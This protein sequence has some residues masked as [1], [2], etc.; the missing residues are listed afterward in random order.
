MDDPVVI[1]SAARTPIG[2]FVGDFA[3]LAAHELGAAAIRAAVQRAGVKPEDVEEVLFGC[4]LQAGLGQ[5][6]ARQ[7]SAASAGLPLAA[8]CTTI[9]KMCG[10]AMKA[11]M[12]AHDLILAGTDRIIVAGGM[13][14][15]DQR[16]LPDAQGARRLPDGPRQRARPHVPG[17]PGGCLRQGPADGH[18]RRGLRAAVRFHPRGAGRVRAG[19]AHARAGREH[20]RHLRLGDRPGDRRRQEGRTSSSA[21]TSSPRRPRR[22]RSRC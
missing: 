1:V 20:R 12:L 15:D 4:V 7:A 6:P 17:R 5:A 9:N 14:I 13:E 11:T 10:S 18:L 22:T 8:G 2:G 3:S 16:A 21:R 19:F